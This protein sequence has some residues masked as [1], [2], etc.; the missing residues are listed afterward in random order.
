MKKESKQA[1]RVYELAKELGIKAQK[2]LE[3]ME[4]LGITAKSTLSTVDADSANIVA[5]YVNEL[6][7]KQKSKGSN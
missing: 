1:K 2:L 6:K 5:D 4:D 3:I 7:Q